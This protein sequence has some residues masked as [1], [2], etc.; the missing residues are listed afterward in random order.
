M[1]HYRVSNPPIFKR[2]DVGKRRI[3]AVRACLDSLFHLMHAV[4]IHAMYPVLLGHSKICLAP[5]NLHARRPEDDADCASKYSIIAHTR[6]QHGTA[7]FVARAYFYGALCTPV[8]ASSALNSSIV[9]RRP[10]RADGAEQESMTITSR[11]RLHSKWY[12]ESCDRAI[13]AAVLQ[14][15]KSSVVHSRVVI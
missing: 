15:R 8:W 11:S 1:L 7:A 9:S 12:G 13:Q 2:V 10:S 14:F 5:L 4:L 3:S 6:Y